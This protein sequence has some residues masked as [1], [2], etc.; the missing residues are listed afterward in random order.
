MAAASIPLD[1][2]SGSLSAA[3]DPGEPRTQSEV[4]PPAIALP[5]GGG[6][7]HGIG[8]KFAA[9]GA[10][11]TGS[12]SVPLATS[13]GRSGFGP[14]LSLS[15]DSGAGNG[16]FGFGWKLAD[17][18]IARKTAKGLPLYR[19]AAE[20]DVFVI[21][22]A[23]DLV[24]VRMAD[25]TR[26]EQ[27]ID[28][29]T[30]HRYRPR[31]EG[32]FARVERWT[33][34]DG[35]VHWRTISG[36]NVLTVYGKDS[37][38]RIAD[39]AQPLRVFRWLIC[40]TRDDKGNCIVYEYKP[41]DGR[42]VDLTRTHERNRG[43]GD[44]A[45]RT[46]N[47]YLKRI[48]YG[49]R[50]SLLDDAGAR[51]RFLTA[52]RIAG[53]G[54]MFDVV[55]DYG[56]HDA[57]AP[58][59]DDVGE[60]EYRADAFSSYRSGFEVRTTR[61]CRRVLM[62][63][64]F[65]HEAD[66]GNDCLVRSTDFTYL[67]GTADPNSPVYTFLREVAQ[68]G[69][70]RQDSGYLK[71]STPPLELEYTEPV[72]QSSVR[73]VDEETLQN[74]PI[75]VDGSAY[76]WIDLHGE[77]IPGILTE[78]AGEWFY[79]RN[80]SPVSD[81]PP[82]FA[83]TILVAEKPN[84][85]INEG[86]ARFMDVAGD[87]RPDVV[88]L[89]GPM[90][91]LHE[92][93]QFEE[94]WGPFKPFSARLNADFEAPSLQ[95]I[96]MNG[97][98]VADVLVKNDDKFVWYESLGEEGF[99]PA[100]HFQQAPDEEVG[101]R[102]VLGD[103][104][105]SIYLAD[106]SGDGL[107]DL[108]RIRNG[109]IC[110]WP[111][112]GRRFGAK[113]AMDDAPVFDHSDQFDHH[114][115]R[116]ADIDG[117]GTVDLIYLHP[118]GIRLYFNR[119]GNGWSPAQTLA[120]A[121][122]IDDVVDVAATDLLG[123]GTACLV[124]SSPLPA[125]TGRQLRYVSLMGGQKPHLLVKTVNNLGA[126]T[127]ISYA[128][129]TKF[130]LNDRRDGNPWIT[131]L[132]FPVHV[133]ERVETY[134]YISRS[135]FVTRYA[136]HHGY[137]DGEEREFR[138]FGFVE[139]WDTELMAALAASSD[140][141]EGDNIED[142]SHV[143]PVCTKTWFHTGIYLGGDRVSNVYE[144]IGAP[145]SGGYYREPTLTDDEFRA[146]LLPDTELPGGLTAADQREA[147]RALKGTMLRQELYA[148]DE[149]PE[150]AHPY[151]VT[152][153]NFHVL[154][155]QERGANR[156]P[157][158][159]ACSNEAINY[160]YERDPSDPRIQ[161]TI[162]LEVD[163]F[164]N[165]LR[166]AT[167]GYGRLQADPDLPTDTDRDKQTKTLVT[168]TVRRM[169]NATVD[170]ADDY[171]LPLAAETR[172]YEL[173]GYV[174][175]GASG[176]YVAADFVPA[177]TEIPYED[178]A[179]AGLQRRL[180]DHERTIYRADDMTALLELGA[181][182][183]RSMPGE[184]YKLV[185]TPGLLDK[186]F[187]RDG[188][189]VLP[190][191]RA[192]LLGSVAGDGGGYVAGDDLKGTGLFPS[193]DADGLWWIP[194]G[195]VFLS[196]GSTDDPGEELAYARMHFFLPHRY[197]DPFGAETFVTYDV[198]DLLMDETRDA[199]GNRVTV[200]ERLPDNSR[201]PAKPG[202]DYRVLQPW[203]LTDPN[204][205][206]TQVIFDTLGM[207]VGTA[208]MGR[209]G[210]A[211]GDSLDG[212]VAD[213]S[214]SVTAAHIADPLTDPLAILGHATSRVVFDMYAYWRS[215]NEAEP[216]PA[217]VY[218][219]TR[220]THDA[221]VG[222]GEETKV[223][224]MFAASDGFGRVI[225]KKLQ[226]EPGPVVSGGAVVEP[227]WVGSGWAIVNNKGK[228]VRQYE[229]FFTATHRF[230]FGMEAGVST[231]V[232]YD[233]VERVVATL[234]PNHTYEKVVTGPWA[235][236]TW[237]T[238]DTVLS[239]P[240][241][242]G[243]V[244]GYTRG[245][246]AALPPSPPA[247][248]W[249]TWRAQRQEGALGPREQAAAEKAA[250]HAGTPTVMHFDALGR[251]FLTVVQN[252]VACPGHPQDG[253]SE[254]LYGR[255]ELDVEGN[256]RVVRD[257]SVQDDDPLGRIIVEHTYDMLGTCM[258]QR[259]MDGG[260]RWTLNDVSGKLVRAWDDRGHDLR[261]EYDALR[262]RLRSFALGAELGEHELLT[263]R[264][265]YGEQLADADA[266]NLR[267]QV[268]LHLDQAG[269]AVAEAHDFKGNA[270]T[271]SRRI[272]TEY[273]EAIDWSA[274]E[275]VLS[276]ASG[277]L[278]DM[279]AV[280]A[281]ISP[282]VE[283]ET[284]T[285]HNTYD[286]LDRPLTIET[287]DTPSSVIRPS[288]NE[289]NLLER[290]DVN[291]RGARVDGETL[292]A[293]FVTN[294]DYDAKGQRERID[295]A[296]GAST[297]Y[298]YDPLTFRLTHL[299]TRRG[300]TAF[301]DDCPQPP[302]M[303]WPGCQIQNLSF[304][305]DAVGNIT[306]LR[307][308][309]QQT[310]FFRNKRVEPSA[311]YTY[312][313]LYR[314]IE[315][316]GREHLGQVGGA[317][318]PQSHDDVPRV[319]LDW[320]AN[321]GNAM[322]TYVERYVYDAVGNF[323]ETKH[324]GSDPLHAGWSRTYEYAETSLIEDGSGG[325]SAK[326]CNRLTSATVGNGNSV[327]DRYVYDS[328]GNV[329]R[330]PHLGGT[331][332]DPNLEW[333]FVDRLRRVDLGGAGTVYY[334]YDARGTRARK[335][336]EKPLGVVEE[337]IYLGGFELYRR[338]DGADR[339]ERETVHVMDGNRRIAL[340]ET[341]TV[342]TAGDDLAPAQ[343]I[344]YQFGNHLGSASIELDDRARIISYEEYYPYGGTSYQAV[345]SQTETPK[346]Y[347][348]SGKE[349]DGE[350]GLYY[351][352]A[353]YY[354]PWLARWISPD[355]SG[356][357]DGVNR[358]AYVHANPIRLTDPSGTSGDDPGAFSIHGKQGLQSTPM[359][360]DIDEPKAVGAQGQSVADARGRA[361][362]VDNRQFLDLLTNRRTKFLGVDSR[363]M[364]PARPPVSVADDPAALI[365]RRFSEITEMQQIFDE[366]VQS[367]RN[368]NGMRPTALKNAINSKIWDI[369]KTGTSD[370][371]VKVRGAFEKLGF[372]NVSGKGFVLRSGPPSDAPVS[373]PIVDPPP[374]ESPGTG[375][376]R[377]LGKVAGPV[378]NVAGIAAIAGQT[379]VDLHEGKPYEATKTAVFGAI[380]YKAM[381]R[382]PALVPLAIMVSTINAYDDK[383]EEHSFAVG[384]WVERKTGSRIVGGV[385]SA[386][387]ATGESLFNGTFGVVGKG[388][389]EGAAVIYIRA[390][391]DEYTLVPWKSQIWADIF[392]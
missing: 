102:L 159:Y 333:D 98:G 61:L 183:H 284:Y 69:Y 279:A 223:Q 283:V 232:F 339:L 385:A 323:L 114:R 259:S 182:G 356:I 218:T 230:E 163:E 359:T 150:A 60:W 103:A 200:G 23:E 254:T 316:T 292:W 101:P 298:D 80:M 219:L 305:Y 31:I 276:P 135:R 55:F 220:E 2:S 137:Y 24:P 113:V 287:P 275:A 57:A 18:E 302:P 175:S 253:T 46:A 139:Q 383:V 209:P 120:V 196:G 348:Y 307:D 161:H 115:L 360:M 324:R 186:V 363:P 6:A 154:Q 74:L 244:T 250:A 245:Y 379:L 212:F 384:S 5:K 95:L 389:G 203:C 375:G 296:N 85:A 297:S 264:L 364:S 59:P 168:D 195:R 251:P 144:G 241:S 140:F 45:R 346:R 3:T 335:V 179:T 390:T 73:D 299:V 273:K 380:A 181:V 118:E 124:W 372:E 329:T 133:V 165:A 132:P 288:Y 190:S 36:D 222:P 354:A 143:P 192:D 267:L 38:S 313:A 174:A 255:T 127:R 207:V 33:R 347:R 147:C 79:K 56:E 39:P 246:F 51:P 7:I 35:D 90:A 233:P 252:V 330:M 97:D 171:R 193:T 91:G 96:D 172:T 352:G 295:Y 231:V 76:R 257:A 215:K 280:D 47:R 336:W 148:V 105:E 129:S 54:W 326:T 239:D 184:I 357:A 64:H 126:E 58:T 71:R 374:V 235:R 247:T 344:R 282:M 119:S 142:A 50:V 337:R 373:D 266:A 67:Q 178:V 377:S 224:H 318:A 158:F 92:H 27:K 265:V 122:A 388:I 199:A 157:V 341:R 185:F 62:F 262:R 13:S 392:D 369:I 214:D 227:R 42:G 108:V 167:I 41:E 263:D 32:L 177:G 322:G 22:D 328:H 198:H 217:L 213:L 53:A 138:G 72:V 320:S 256:Q 70:R 15:Y 270:L 206:R 93:D 281:A 319:G 311:D 211:L 88:V 308:E 164:G 197:R 81:R 153:Q 370:A 63:H 315:A 149:T 14:H 83:P 221:E 272:A 300:A 332:P 30:V 8:E 4:Q 345:R 82:E 44:D 309:A 387:A 228:P 121:P 317:P 234:H 285:Q 289:A 21:S 358:Y 376:G 242:D 169:T 68:S 291:I 75:G 269:A 325:T 188:S 40:E 237:D 365:T 1:S 65:E 116:L 17:S 187:V 48:R 381:S 353:R 340:V 84:L 87:G 109:E 306:D 327:S 236:V 10:T 112:C 249:E 94:T 26:V 208:V 201:D 391:S 152:E 240:R 349:R 258:H 293:T 290:V 128:P 210:D 25:G 123:N 205:N 89:D 43:D 268:Y 34:L 386:T 303:D 278:L 125:D 314:L 294:I 351:H 146:S 216:E 117:T 277:E 194:A 271:T 261:F 243:D 238:N 136:Y 260:E 11:G 104:T 16:A 176:R 229:P 189:D 77:G 134:D 66:V 78:Q 100:Q 366:A 301:P 111:N 362:D 361:L 173:T 141:P 226:A 312:D 368:P 225:Q 367:V 321:D 204:R 28:N 131:R 334:V 180:I 350:T 19:D 191:N 162:T 202:N 160:H 166:E 130:F 310:I 12:L 371:A 304:T 342:D 170:D 338:K 378:A 145:G 86:R 29:Y 106:M 274:L 107:T 331:H 52:A 9:N 20:S 286:A 151:T 343:L 99:G 382:Y 49:N 248:A 37:N 355:P 110:Y 156:H 155:L